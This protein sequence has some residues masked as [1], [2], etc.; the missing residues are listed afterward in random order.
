METGLLLWGIGT[1]VPEFRS[2][3]LPLAR[4]YCTRNWLRLHRFVKPWRRPRAGESEL[5]QCRCL[6][7]R[8]VPGPPDRRTLPCLRSHRTPLSIVSHDSKTPC[9]AGRATHGASA[10]FRPRICLL[11]WRRWHARLWTAH[12]SK[13]S[14]GMRPGAIRGAA[15]ASARRPSEASV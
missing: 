9:S 14:D 3:V 15:S 1:H 12:R 11:S 10:G 7:C 13:R 4:L 2:R 5:A 8:A 6:T